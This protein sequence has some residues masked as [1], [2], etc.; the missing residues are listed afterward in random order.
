MDDNSIIDLEIG[1]IDYK[2]SQENVSVI[3]EKH[4]LEKLTIEL[5][6]IKNKKYGKE[7]EHMEKNDDSEKIFSNSPLT[8]SVCSSDSE[9]QTENQTE[10][11][12]NKPKFK[13]LTFTEV[14][15]AINK[16]ISKE[17][18]VSSELD[19]LLTYL[20]GQTHIYSQSSRIT[21]QKFNYLMF[22]A[23]F[24]TGSMTVLSPFLNAI[25]WSNW[26]NSLL[27][28]LLTVLITINNFMKWQAVAA[29]F[30]TISNQFDKLAIS[31]EMSRNTFLFIDDTNEKSK[32]ILEKMR[33]TE[34]RIMNIQNNYNDIIIPYEVL[35]LNPIIANINIFSFIKKI[36]HYKKTLI[37]KYKDIKN[38]I[39]ELLFKIEREQYATE[40]QKNADIE[41]LQIFL[42]KKEDIK[43]QII[44]NSNNNVYAYIDNLFIREIQHSEKYYT[45]N[46]FG[47][48]VLF[49]PTTLE[50]TSYGNPV[51][52]EYLN[53]IFTKPTTNNNNKQIE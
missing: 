42:D 1:S 50:R 46:G 3:S 53:F 52:D 29:I 18:Q 38:A 12:A 23:I 41:K 11:S 22:P 21:M 15:T 19:I 47:M 14:E 13:K 8:M 36:E 37:V 34:E 24:I 10:N 20:K 30:L 26:L 39:G 25:G 17:M 49:K 51:V 33:D 32:M 4:F 6:E 40:L 44:Q 16:N 9:N 31:V 43:S 7:S 2:S 48:F 35:L 28:A 27:N 45:Y 5:D